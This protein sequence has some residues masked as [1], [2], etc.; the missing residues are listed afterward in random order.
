MD[1]SLPE[2]VSCADAPPP[3]ARAA[4]RSSAPRARSPPAAPLWATTVITRF[5]LSMAMFEPPCCPD[6]SDYNIC[7]VIG[8][9][10][11]LTVLTRLALTEVLVTM[12]PWQIRLRIC[13]LI[14]CCTVL[15]VLRSL[16]LIEVWVTH[17]VTLTI[18][19]AYLLCHWQ[20]L[21]H[22]PVLTIQ[23]TLSLADC[24]KLLHC[25]DCSD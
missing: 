22:Y 7:F 6:D 9:C 5:A 24:Y 17:N 12:L 11:V 1:I 8:Y 3:I 16:V 20:C 23:I 25:L 15:T 4:S 19:I 14:G 21:S 18:Q 13:F 2:W 10:T